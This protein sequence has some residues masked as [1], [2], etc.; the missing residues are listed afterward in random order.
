MYL[1]LVATALRRPASC[2]LESGSQRV[3][4]RGQGAVV[5][6]PSD[7][8]PTRLQHRST[9]ALVFDAVQAIDSVLDLPAPCR[10]GRMRRG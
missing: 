3:T 5:Y 6:L 10:E 1:Q 7:C 9:S 8:A 2:L 4:R